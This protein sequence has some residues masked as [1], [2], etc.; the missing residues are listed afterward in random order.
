MC[1]RGI[2]TLLLGLWRRRR[3]NPS[4]V[5]GSTIVVELTHLCLNKLAT[6]LQ[7]R[8]RPSN[9]LQM[10]KHL[11]R[12][13]MRTHLRDHPFYTV[14]KIIFTHRINTIYAYIISMSHLIIPTVSSVFY[15]SYP[16]IMQNNIK[17]I[18]SNYYFVALHNA[19]LTVFSAYVFQGLLKI[20]MKGPIVFTHN[21]Y[22]QDADFSYYNWIFYLSKY[23]EFLDTFIIYSKGRKP[24]FLQTFHH[25]GAV[26]MWHM[27]YYNKVD[28][29]GIG[30]LFNSGVHT[31][32][33]TYYLLNHLKFNLSSIK[34]YITYIQITQLL[35]ANL[36][37]LI[38][39]YPPR[40]TL[41]NYIIIFVSNMYIVTLVY[42]FVN[43][44]SK[45][46]K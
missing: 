1:K 8:A 34:N 24:I 42:L 14:P 29:I 6:Y 19:G 10:R 39:Y 45:S 38:L 43:F 28:A 20:Y 31:I 13:N 26:W 22:Y 44:L 2:H 41:G 11:A 18:L 9:P 36:S 3:L 23:Y 46:K 12:I 21:H 40:E 35:S 4:G 25:L 27:S 7:H 30:S 5:H 33:Y 15:L 32:M 16:Y 37:S 17:S